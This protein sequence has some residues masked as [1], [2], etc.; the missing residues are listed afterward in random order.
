M[1]AGLFLSRRRSQSRREAGDRDALAGVFGAARRDAVERE[2]LLDVVLH[3]EVLAVGREDDALG[4]A[5]GERFARFRR[6]PSAH[7]VELHAAVLG[8]ERIVLAAIG[9][10]GRGDRD[11]LVV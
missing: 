11:P 5:A 9:P 8:A 2:L 3:D 10:V 7:P 6:L 1:V 4:I